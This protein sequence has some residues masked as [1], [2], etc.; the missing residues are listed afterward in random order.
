MRA[1]LCPVCDCEASMVP[2]GNGWLVWC[3][4]RYDYAP[5]DGECPYLKTGFGATLQEATE[6][7]NTAIEA[8]DA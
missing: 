1:R 7:W 8:D 4:N 5:T 3:D 6:K 2:Q